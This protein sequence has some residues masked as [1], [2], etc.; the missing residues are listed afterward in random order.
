LKAH[1]ALEHFIAFSARPNISLDQLSPQA[2]VELMVRFYIEVRAEDCL[3]EEDG[4][5]LLFQWGIY[6]WGAGEFFEYNIT[7][8]FILA[9][10][11]ETE[12]EESK[13]EDCRDDWIGQ[14]ALTLKYVPLAVLRSVPA[15][16]RWCRHPN[17]LPEF[18]AFI[19]SC[20]ATTQVRELPVAATRITFDNA[21]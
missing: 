6:N 10:P 12:E 14:L 5:M 20:E 9:Q 4:D 7:R 2:A 13:N 15:S 16:N 8:Q 19:Q 1:D 11:L 17:E 18:V 21:E 3:F